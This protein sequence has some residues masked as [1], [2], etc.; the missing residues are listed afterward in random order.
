[1]LP[2]FR[3]PPTPMAYISTPSVKNRQSNTRTPAKTRLV[4]GGVRG[5][6]QDSPGT[7]GAARTR[8]G[9]R[10]HCYA[11]KGGQRTRHVRPDP[12]ERGRVAVCVCDPLI[13][14]QEDDSLR[15][16]VPG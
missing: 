1:M 8:R 16:R 13:L 6:L 7:D 2:A 12:F 3:R 15:S 11:R 5:P 9:K 10:K 14:S 4:S